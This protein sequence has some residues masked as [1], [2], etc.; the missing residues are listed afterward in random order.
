MEGRTMVLEDRVVTTDALRTA[1]NAPD[2][3]AGSLVISAALLDRLEPTGLH[4]VIPG[5]NVRGPDEPTLVCE[6][7]LAAR[8]ESEPVRVR[9]LVILDDYERLVTAFEALRAASGLIPGIAESIPS[10]FAATDDSPGEGMSASWQGTAADTSRS[11]KD[12]PDP[13]H[14]Q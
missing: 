5:A 1:A 8:G 7:V 6:L 9:I 10:P 14:E 2:G 4:V 12:G 13:W 11:E 3:N